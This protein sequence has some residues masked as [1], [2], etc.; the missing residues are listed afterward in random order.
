M[1][2]EWTPRLALGVETID[3]QHKELF[4]RVNDLVSAMEAVRG[5]AEVRRILSFLGDYVLTHF[6][7]EERL[8]RHHAYPDLGKHKAIHDAFVKD[9]GALKAQV[10]KD[11]PSAAIAV[12]LNGRV[13]GWLLDHIGVTD[14]AFAQFLAKSSKPE[15]RP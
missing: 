10:V 1:A 11:G 15:A 7:A 2:I 5:E 3:L 4:K 9:L 13:C 8:M 14:R 12:Q 6:E